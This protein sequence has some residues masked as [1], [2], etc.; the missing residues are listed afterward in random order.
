MEPPNS[1]L[2][3]RSTEQ[4]VTTSRDNAQ[5]LSPSQI[6]NRAY[7]EACDQQREMSRDLLPASRKWLSVQGFCEREC[8][9]NPW[10]VHGI[11]AQAGEI[12]EFLERFLCLNRSDSVIEKLRATP[13]SGRK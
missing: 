4:S 1:E 3:P 12:K 10:T 13:R 11:V 5:A 7:T 9:A 8:T 6:L 2:N